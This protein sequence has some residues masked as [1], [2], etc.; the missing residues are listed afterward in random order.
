MSHS[1]RRLVEGIQVTPCLFQHNWAFSGLHDFFTVHL[2]KL[3]TFFQ[4]FEMIE[5]KNRIICDAN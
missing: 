1:T 2:F 3:L 4:T 5:L